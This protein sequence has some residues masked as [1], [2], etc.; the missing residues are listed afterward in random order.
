[1]IVRPATSGDA[2]PWVLVAPALIGTA[3]FIVLPLLCMGIYSFW[4][5]QP[6]G[7]VDHS[8]TFAN[9]L[10]YA[11]DPFYALIL[12]DTLRVAAA[13]TILCVLIGYPPAYALSLIGPRWKGLLIVLL[14]LPSWISYVVRTMS[15][16]YVLGRNGLINTIL[17]RLGAIE[18][19][20]PLLYNEFSVHLG[21]V[22]YLLPL[23]I[24]NI[25]IGIQSVDRNLVT[26]ARTLGATNWQAFLAVTFPLSLP[27]IGAGSL[28]VFILSAGSYITPLVLGGPGTMFYST[29]IYESIIRQLNWAFGATVS[30][31]FIFVLGLAVM[32][33]TR[34]AGLSHLMREPR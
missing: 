26:A 24:L 32:I 21:L 9:W 30:L 2:V 13:T 15:W 12:A 4:T 8:L 3:A 29:L 33:Y 20:L 25:Y 27:G 31:V 19:P 22:H 6:G 11:Q 17:S 7:L 16:L 10:E 28:L 1:M 14:F 23:M 5:Q 18:E 34:V